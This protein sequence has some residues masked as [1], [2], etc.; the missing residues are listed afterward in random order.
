MSLSVKE[1]NF[2]KVGDIIENI[3]TS[4]R[5]LVIGAQHGSIILW[6]SPESV[7]CVPLHPSDE[8]IEDFF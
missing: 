7:V 4:G 5:A 6:I 1:D 2:L 8:Y 3:A